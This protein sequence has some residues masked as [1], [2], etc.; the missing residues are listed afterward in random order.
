MRNL[1][2]RSVMA[3]FEI[4]TKEDIQALAQIDPPLQAGDILVHK[5]FEY[6]IL[7]GELKK[8][9]DSVAIFPATVGTDIYTIYGY[10]TSVV[11]E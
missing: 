11:V 8:V 7:D 4:N 9:F 2:K 1:K 5:P 3:I 10:N 6:Y